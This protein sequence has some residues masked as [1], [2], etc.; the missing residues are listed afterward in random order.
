MRMPGWFD[1]S[2]LDKLS[3]SRHDDEKGLLESISAVD[4][5]IQAEIDSGIPESRII[6]GGFSQGGA[7]AVLGGLTGKRKLGGV[8]GL[9]TWVPLNHKVQEV[10]NDNNDNEDKDDD[11][12]RDI[13]EDD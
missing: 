10:R 8:I 6:L 2:T 7:V 13:G 5:L 9:S 4:S 11:S 1:L 12:E 3:D